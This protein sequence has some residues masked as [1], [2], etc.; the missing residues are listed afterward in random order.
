MSKAVASAD[1]IGRR[2]VEHITPKVGLIA[3]I[4]AFSL[5]ALTADRALAYDASSLPSV[6]SVDD[7]MQ[8]GQPR[9]QEN[10][11][12]PYNGGGPY[13]GPGNQG[14]YN[15]P[16]PRQPKI[17]PAV[18]GATLV[19]L[20]ALQRYQESRRRPEMRKHHEPRHSRHRNRTSQSNVE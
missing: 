1:S 19:A 14:F 16:G 15:P 12:D 17:N 5:I 13:M 8:Q 4:I 20:W 9:E 3:A 11:Q 18:V 2:Q 10:G 7:Y 6:G